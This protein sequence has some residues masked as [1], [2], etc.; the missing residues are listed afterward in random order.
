[1]TTQTKPETSSANS[2]SKS[3]QVRALLQA[4]VAPGQIAKQV[5]CS[6]NLVYMIKAEGTAS[7]KL[8]AST[9][10]KPITGGFDADVDRIVRA[11][12]QDQRETEALRDGLTRI[13]QI[14]AELLR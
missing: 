13:Q 10:V 1:M 11:I 14:V 7:G 8:V 3:D 12:R 9:T 4:G 6:R 2:N 5:G